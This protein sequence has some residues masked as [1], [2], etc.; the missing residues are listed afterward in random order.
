MPTTPFFF[1][2]PCDF[3]QLFGLLLL[4]IFPSRG[5][6]KWGGGGFIHPNRRDSQSWMPAD[7]SPAVSRCC[8]RVPCSRMALRCLHCCS[9]R[10]WTVLL[11][12]AP[13]H[14]KVL[15]LTHSCS[16]NVCAIAEALPLPKGPIATQ[17]VYDDGGSSVVS[18]ISPDWHCFSVA[19]EH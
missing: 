14:R 15:A 13:P 3:G 2:T 18:C 17:W 1:G 6:Y 9:R 19:T 7:C 16:W 4:H 12:G 10:A 8:F 11:C 5:G